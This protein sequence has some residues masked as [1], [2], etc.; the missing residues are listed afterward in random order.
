V[1]VWKGEGVSSV[2][3]KR[4]IVWIGFI[5]CLFFPLDAFNS[6]GGTSKTRLMNILIQ[7]RKCVNHPYLFDGKFSSYLGASLLCR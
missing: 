4:L 1:S 7:L 3:I 2:Y 6:T 5:S